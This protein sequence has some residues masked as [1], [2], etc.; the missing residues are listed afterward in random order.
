MR[1]S[2][3]PVK[4]GR[5]ISRL[6]G[7]RYYHSWYKPHVYHFL[8][9]WTSLY[10]Y[11]LPKYNYTIYHNIRLGKTKLFHSTAFENSVSRMYDEPSTPTLS[12]SILF[13]FFLGWLRKWKPQETVNLDTSNSSSLH[14]NFGPRSSIISLPTIGSE[15]NV[16]QRRTKSGCH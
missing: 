6:P 10:L 11:C 12:L 16:E 1:W 9:R 7:T 13:P 2:L 3:I 5:A 15:Y 4:D 8:K 14:R